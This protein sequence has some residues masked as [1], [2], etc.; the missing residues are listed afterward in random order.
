MTEFDSNRKTEITRGLKRK[1]LILCVI[2]YLGTLV[3]VSSLVAADGKVFG[4]DISINQDIILISI[5]LG[6]GTMFWAYYS[7]KQI[8]RNRLP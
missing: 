8:R 5:L 6:V 2:Q 3:M 7:R 1:D 4:A